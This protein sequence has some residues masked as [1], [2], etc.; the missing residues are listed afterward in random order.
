MGERI[1]HVGHP[2]R[3]PS[4]LRRRPRRR[5]SSCRGPESAVEPRAAKPSGLRRVVE[6]TARALRSVRAEQHE[7]TESCGATEKARLSSEV[8]QYG[9][10]WHGTQSPAELGSPIERTFIIPLGAIYPPT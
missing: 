2:L 1:S 3:L 8:T 4:R 10:F 6:A 5:K 7:Q 9:H